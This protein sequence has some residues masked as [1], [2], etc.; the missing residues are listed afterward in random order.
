VDATAQIERAEEQATGAAVDARAVRA[1]LLVAL[2]AL[3]LA[4]IFALC[5]VIGRAPVL[6]LLI[7]DVQL[8]RRLLVVHVDLALV[9]W[10]NAFLAGLVCLLPARSF[11]PGLARAGALVAG[12]GTALLLAGLALVGA[13]PVLANY[14]PV[15]DHPVHLGAL[16]LFAAGVVL[17]LLDGRLLPG[18]EA[19]ASL[20]PLPAAARPGLRAAGVAVLLAVVTL[21]AALH[22][23][24]AGLTPRA[25]WELIAWGPGH[26]LQV[27]S[28]CAM[29]ATWLV[30]AGG[31]LGREPLP[32]PA[33]S[34]LFAALVLPLLGAPVLTLGGTTE[35]A[36]HAGFTRLMQLGIAPP[37]LLLLA[38]V[39]RPV[40]R[41]LRRGEVVLADPR[42]T[43]LFASAALTLLGVALGAMIR[44]PSTVVPGHYH[45]ALGG[46]T[47]SFMA[48]T[49]LVLQGVGRP[50]P[51]RLRRLAAWQ[52]AVY[53]AGQV[54]FAI[55]FALAG[56]PRKVYGVEQVRRTLQE[57]LGLG[58]MATGGLFAVGG[59]AL[60]LWLVV[61]A[62]RSPTTEEVA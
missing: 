51:G 8:M 2:A 31:A 43:G 7:T 9:V 49:Y 13:P 50:L 34:A 22:V 20:I 48:V 47:A 23:T 6:D 52:P 62:W 19:A 10:F 18:R 5:L 39:L 35:I 27:A 42:V 44:G 28:V 24:P 61:A 1:W 4:G 12:A 53:G 21:L 60:F 38:L 33:A 40:V 55:G 16:L 59:G 37:L 46:V 17:A 15:I 26:V 32:R 11:A 57:T 30:L 29:G 54:V 3:T 45:A 58:V 41:G 14:V 36:Y 25:R 56:A